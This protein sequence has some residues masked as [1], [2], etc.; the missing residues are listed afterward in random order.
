MKKTLN[1]IIFIALF[2]AGYF[3]VRAVFPK[4]VSRYP[5][6]VVLLLVDLYLWASV[7]KKV[8]KQ[9]WFFKYLITCLYWLPVALMIALMVTSFFKPIYFWDS[10][11]RTYGVG[12]VF[13][14][15]TAKV[16]TVLFLFIADIIR[17]F[18]HLYRYIIQKKRGTP[19]YAGKKISRSKFLVN[20]GYVT[21][22]IAFSGLLIGMFKWVYQFKIHRVNLKVAKLPERFNGLKIVQI[23]DLHLGSWASAEPLKEAVKM[24]N[25]LRPDLVFF[26]GDLVNFATREAF[27][28]ENE[29]GQ[30]QSKY[31]IYTILG[32]HD[33]G[34]YVNW[35]SK[36]AKEK[37]MQQIYDLYERLGWRLLRNENEILDLDGDRMAIVGVENWS[38]NSRFPRHGDLEKALYNT[39]DVPVKILLTHDPSH[40]E[41]VVRRKYADINLTLSGHT[42]G[43]QFGIE[44]E[45]F[46]WSPAQYVYKQWAGLYRNSGQEQ[47]IYV[48][49]GTGF[50]GYPGRIGILPEITEINLSS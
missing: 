7:K 17:A 47:Y 46:K 10:G 3:A 43:F 49:R 14:A 35:E 20:M 30:I 21:G 19:E 50:I 40:W 8:F 34:D 44:T 38:A 15:Y 26:T 22:G 16:F 1:V 39:S 32:N 28:F 23:S 2:I 18:K 31:G 25:D 33:Y 11:F 29:L 24:I 36:S 9:S 13:V 5:F 42:H 37:N 6:F 41:K 12:L 4:E 48:N 45:N 27:R